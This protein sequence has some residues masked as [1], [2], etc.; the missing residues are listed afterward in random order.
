MRF[1]NVTMN[2]FKQINR[3]NLIIIIN[4]NGDDDTRKKNFKKKEKTLKNS[5]IKSRICEKFKKTQ[6]FIIQKNK[7][8]KKNLFKVITT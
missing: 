2:E 3:I 1:L 6:I 5:Q 8:R 4:N 7:Y